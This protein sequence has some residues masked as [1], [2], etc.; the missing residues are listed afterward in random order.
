M[1]IPCPPPGRASPRTK[2]VHHGLH[3]RST[4]RVL[5]PGDSEFMLSRVKTSEVGVAQ[6]KRLLVELLL[7]SNQTE[8]QTEVY[9][10]SL[11]QQRLWFLDQLGPK[12]AAYNVHFGM[13]LR[14][15]LDMRA[16]QS[17]L[18][19]LTNRHASLRT[20]FRLERG[21]LVQVVA[22]RLSVRLPVTDISRSAN[23]EGEHYQLAKAEVEESFDL[24]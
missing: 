13:E 23:P 16:L 17:S 15:P 4:L 5:T 21:E 1:L 10:A 24:S 18:Q 22:S 14:G 12:S 19:E 3:R 8:I 9:P 7:Q 11:A 20:V 6:Q 2:T